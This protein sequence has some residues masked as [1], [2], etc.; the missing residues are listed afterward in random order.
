[1]LTLL[2]NIFYFIGTLIYLYLIIAGFIMTFYFF[3]EDLGLYEFQFNEF[4]RNLDIKSGYSD[5]TENDIYEE[6]Y[7]YR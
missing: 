4:Q 7:Y 3:W 2:F 1:M 5:S 6:E